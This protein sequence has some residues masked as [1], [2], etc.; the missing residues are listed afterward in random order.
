MVEALQHEARVGA[1]RYLF[2]QGPHG[3]FFPQLGTALVAAGHAVHRINL[4]GGDWATWPTGENYAGTRRGWPAH[5]ARVVAHHAISD[6]VLFG[7]SRP[8]HTDAIA[9]AGA[10]GVRVHVFEEGYIRPD[11]V[12]LERDGVNG[13]SSLSRDPAWYRRE[14][15]ALPALPHHPPLPSY[16][17]AR[18]W[19]AF[20]Y[21]VQAVLRRWRF[22]LHRDHRTSDPV[23]E[24]GQFLLRFGRRARE[25][26]R[27]AADEQ[28][29][30]GNAYVLFPL[31]LTSDYQIRIHSP[32]DDMHAAIGHVLDSFARQAPADMMLAVKEHPL[33][34]GIVDWRRKVERAAQER[35]VAGRVAFMEQGDLSTLI[36]GSRGVVTVN[37]TSGT[38][39]LAAGKPVR[40]LGRAVYD[41]PDLTD[42]A[43]LD[44]FWSN[45][46]APDAATYDA[47]C[48][49]LADRVLLHGAF[50]SDVGMP[51][52]LDA[53]V[54]R[55]TAEDHPR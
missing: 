48:R 7:D 27:S 3:L 24:G 2:L 23:W 25:A 15:A 46:R 38:L 51:A 34:S 9:V 36:A 18:R 29:L 35:G 31:Q 22:P 17:D 20:F 55:L 13:R 16:A 21:Y 33:D 41:M 6:I 49:V 28:R 10:R 12:T 14:A 54:A 44:D 37:S 19:A 1:R 53:A 5:V 11:W 39:A 4:N 50:L 32:F 30:A 42:Q 43:R 26:R 52:L 45:P 47:F 8:L 40:V